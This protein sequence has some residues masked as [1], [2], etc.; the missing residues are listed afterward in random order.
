MTS[1]VERPDSSRIQNG[2][3]GIFEDNFEKNLS[4]TVIKNTHIRSRCLLENLRCFDNLEMTSKI[5]YGPSQ[6]IYGYI[7]DD[8]SDYFTWVSVS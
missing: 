8:T 4:V 6:L 2:G 5:Y 3:I 7:S 1:K